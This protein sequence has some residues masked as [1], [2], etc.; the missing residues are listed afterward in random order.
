MSNCLVTGRIFREAKAG[1]SPV[2][3]AHLIRG[4]R[5]KTVTEIISGVNPSKELRPFFASFAASREIKAW[6]LV[7]SLLFTQ[8]AEGAKKIVKTTIILKADHTEAQS[9]IY[10]K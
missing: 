9:H 8:D 2:R 3:R 6:F 4:S 1:F 7:R 5:K 10:L